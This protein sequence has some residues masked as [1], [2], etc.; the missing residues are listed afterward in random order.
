MRW[1]NLPGSGGIICAPLSEKL[2]T[3]SKQKKFVYLSDHTEEQAFD[4]LAGRSPEENEA[5]TTIRGQYMSHAIE[6]ET[7]LDGLL[8]ALYLPSLSPVAYQ[9]RFKNFVLGSTGLSFDQKVSALRG[10]STGSTKENPS[11]TVL[12]ST[13]KVS[14]PKDKATT[15]L[16]K[17][18]TKIIELRN[19]IAHSNYELTM[20]SRSSGDKSSNSENITFFLDVFSRSGSSKPTPMSK[21]IVERWIADDQPVIN[22]LKQRA[23]E[24]RFNDFDSKE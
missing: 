15:E 9:M 5:I 6:V 21:S 24:L 7:A 13:R 11:R 23:Y 12:A 1:S 3:G 17:K 8:I 20:R 19:A 16:V 2:W 22:E 4:L 10:A 14:P 18:I